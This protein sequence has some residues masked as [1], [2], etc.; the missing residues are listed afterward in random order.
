M[1]IQHFSSLQRSLNIKIY[2]NN[3]RR[4]GGEV[5]SSKGIILRP[6][7]KISEQ[8][9]ATATPVKKTT[10]LAITKSNSISTSSLDGSESSLEWF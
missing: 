2:K 8:Q 5:D 6:L 3:F 9:S 10:T 1:V 4:Y 7:S